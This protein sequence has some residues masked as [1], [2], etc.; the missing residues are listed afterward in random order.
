MHGF[1]N[2]QQIQH[3]VWGEG[4]KNAAWISYKF[5]KIHIQMMEHILY[6]RRHHQELEAQ[7]L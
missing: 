1:M 2:I 7:F 3:I 5:S 4:G 6:Y